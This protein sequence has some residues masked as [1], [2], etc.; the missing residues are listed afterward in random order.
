MTVSGAQAWVFCG[1]T[2]YIH[3]DTHNAGMITQDSTHRFVT[4]TEK[5][6]WNNKMNY[7]SIA[8]DGDFNTVTAAGIYHVS[9][10]TGDNRPD[11]HGGTLFVGG[12]GSNAFVHQIWI[13]DSPNQVFKRFKNGTAG[14]TSWTE[15]LHG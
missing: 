13:P 7:G 15:L 6:T 1:E 9:T 5:T 10:G 12:G 4:D 14:W 11:E 8:S 3:P 2:R